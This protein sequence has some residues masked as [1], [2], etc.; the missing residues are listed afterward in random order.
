MTRQD[1]TQNSVVAVFGHYS[2]AE[3]AIRELKDGGF[4]VKKLAVV[5]RD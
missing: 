4:D 3:N 2:A 1:R 5:G